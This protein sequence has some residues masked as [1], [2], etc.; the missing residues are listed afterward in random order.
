M[1]DSLTYIDKCFVAALATM[2]ASYLSRE[3]NVRSASNAAIDTMKIKTLAEYYKGDPEKLKTYDP[4]KLDDN[5]LMRTYV[6]PLV[7]DNGETLDLI[8]N[9]KGQDMACVFLDEDSK[10]HQFQL[11][12]RMKNE[13]MRNG[14][15]GIETKLNV[16][17]FLEPKTLEEFTEAVSK[18]DLV[19]KSPR[20]TIAKVKEKD[21]NAEI[22]MKD[23]EIFEIEDEENKSPKEVQE[24]ISLEENRLKKM[25]EKV[26]MSL[27]E[28]KRFCKENKLTS[29]SVKGAIEVMNI[30]QLE[31]I[32]DGRQLN[33]SGE[34]SVVIIR[35]QENGL[36][37]R[38]RITG[39]DGKTLLDNS[40]YDDQI[41]PLVPEYQTSEPIRDLDEHADEI[42]Q[43]NE[44]EYTDTNG[45]ERTTLVQGN[46]VD[47]AFFE[48]KFKEIEAE[49]KAKLASIN[50]SDM[51]PEEKSQAKENLAGDFYAD[52]KGLE[53]ESG[54]IASEIADETLANAEDAVVENTK[55]QIKEDAKDVLAVTG[56]VA[57]AAAIVATD[58]T[59]GIAGAAGATIAEVVEKTGA[60]LL[61]KDEKEK[62]D[63]YGDTIDHYGRNLEEPHEKKR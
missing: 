49:Y 30:E 23:D 52:V 62:D 24:E 53:R 39:K 34:G 21:P 22:Q 28:M 32:L 10:E 25:A 50:D 35:T 7:L 58:V 5:K 61:K 54:V 29:K 20:D 13:I 59:L 2:N 44:V 43:L 63:G 16:A 27:E 15:D 1:S 38:A 56:A 57:G 14:V 6:I 26:G 60:K 36:Q 47:A 46:E 18:D 19:P 8:V 51:T 33:R 4:S 55:T 12:P 11:T 41:A 31:N 9:S 45:K 17:D 42:N 48:E 40:K 3:G 37:N